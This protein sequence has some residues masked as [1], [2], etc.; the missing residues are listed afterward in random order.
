MSFL[1]PYQ[2]LSVLQ[3]NLII[4][5]LQ[6]N[7]NITNF[8][9]KECIKIYWPSRIEKENICLPLG[10]LTA[11]RGAF[12]LL[13]NTIKHSGGTI[14]L[15]L[16]QQLFL[17]KNMESILPIAQ[18]WN[19]KPGFGKTVTCIDAIHRYNMN[20]TIV[21][22]RTC[23]K[24]QWEEEIAKYLPNTKLK[25]S[26]TMISKLCDHDT[27]NIVIVDEAHLIVTKKGVEMLSNIFPKILIGLSGSFFR[28]DEFHPFLS[29]FF[30]EPISLT[31]EAA[32][33][34]DMD[35][36]RTVF[37]KTIESNIRP[38][39]SHNSIGGLDWSTVLS[40][41]SENEERNRL[42]IDIVAQ[43]SEKNILIL[44][45][46]IK[47]GERLISLLNE[48]GE[49]SVTG[50]F[51]TKKIID[52]ESRIIISTIQKIGT[53]ISIDK[54]DCLILATDVVKYYIQYVSRI[55]RTKTRDS[56]VIDIIDDNFVLQK[57]FRERKKIYK[58]L[59][60]VK[61]I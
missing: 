45:K 44:V 35:T 39:I 51:G 20:A 5:G 49:Q 22:N 23:L 30:G 40:S 28:Y 12:S 6:K 1:I 16:E 53:G 26:V 32:R 21:V 57:H 36:T 10:F 8:G 42:I 38:T 3:K 24:K 48:S 47:H 43:H 54:L 31:D 59:H 52:T 46:Y 29:W 58:E 13:S 50:C 7:V 41:L 18:A 9:K 4:K 33:V 19:L 61:F 56:L 34:M 55:L 2:N 25:I 60:G 11:H 15:R 27:N 14:N 37:I 17:E